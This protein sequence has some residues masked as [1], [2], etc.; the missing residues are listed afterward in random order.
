M[1]FE[2]PGVAVGCEHTVA[3]NQLVDV[4]VVV[5]GVVVVVLLLLLVLVVARIRI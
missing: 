4:V 2:R 1:F 3:N 5:V